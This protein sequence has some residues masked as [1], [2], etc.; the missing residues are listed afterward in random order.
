MK[1]NDR[2]SC[3]VAA[4]SST[5]SQENFFCGRA[6]RILS[7]SHLGSNLPFAAGNTNVSLYQFQELLTDMCPIS[8][9]D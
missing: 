5:A 2:S 8:H 7:P 3:G 9:T 1:L 4:N 6:Q